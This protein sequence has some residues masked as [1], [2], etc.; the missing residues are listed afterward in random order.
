MPRPSLREALVHAAEQE[1]HQHGYHGT[2]V[3]AIATAAGA[4]KG[5]FYNHFPSKE[6]LA[7]EVADR[8]AERM[9]PEML[10]DPEVAPL[11]RIRGHF[12]FLAAT[13]ASTGDRRGCL[14]GNLAAETGASDTPVAQR[15]S[16]LFDAWS[17]TLAGAVRAA[18]ADGTVPATV[19]AELVAA[20]LIDV[21]EGAVLRAKPTGDGAAVQRVLQ[22]AMPRLLE[23]DGG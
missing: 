17:G 16:Q 9:R 19:D 7:V 18:Q 20:E 6:H 23:V 2:G 8:Y 12:A 5:S 1:F 13:A 14:L 10:T 3:A 22:H 4:P 15:V 21:Y 11:M